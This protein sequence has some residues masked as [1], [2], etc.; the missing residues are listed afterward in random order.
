MPI[1]LNENNSNTLLIVIEK[2]LEYITSKYSEDEW[3][4]Y[5]ITCYFKR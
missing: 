4:F 5:G 3:I 1:L 2:Q